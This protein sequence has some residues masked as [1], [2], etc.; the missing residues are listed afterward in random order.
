MTEK[1]LSEQLFEEEYVRAIDQQLKEFVLENKDVFQAAFI[2]DRE[3]AI[4]H[5]QVL[6]KMYS[7]ILLCFTENL[8][9]TSHEAEKLFLAKIVS[10]IHGVRM[11]LDSG[12]PSEAL[13]VTR[14]LLECYI[15]LKYMNTKFDKYADLYVN[16]SLYERYFRARN[17]AHDYTTEHLVEFRRDYD[18]VKDHYVEK[19]PWYYKVLQRDLLEKYGRN[20]SNK[21]KKKPSLMNMAE[22]VGLIESYKIDY[23]IYSVPVHAS[24]SMQFLHVREG[25]YW[26]APN[27]DERIIDSIVYSTFNYAYKSLDLVLK[28]EVK[29]KTELYR[30]YLSYLWAK[31]TENV[32]P[33]YVE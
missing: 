7:F 12:C 17:N 10:N 1:S 28:R 19:K 9:E 8:F 18:K 11:L 26:L 22:L 13:M 24:S 32:K 20:R 2:K 25:D 31:V 33:N 16:H 30:T 14:G 3:K 4:P 6:D 23:N 27:F 15:L 29:G 21:P 5:T